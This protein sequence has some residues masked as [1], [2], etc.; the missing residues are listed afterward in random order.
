MDEAGIDTTDFVAS[1]AQHSTV[2]FGGEL[3]QHLLATAP[4][5]DAVF[6]CNDDL[7][8]GVLFACQ[9]LNIRVPADLSIL[10]FN[11]LDFAAS[12][13]PAL[14]SVATPRH[15]M[16]RRAAEIILQIIRAPRQRPAETRVDLGFKI[17]EWEST[18]RRAGVGP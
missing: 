17:S 1:S 4:G 8:L 13:Y 14:T 12:A 11:D 2:K 9:R 6:C 18:R 16:A 5:I 10:G 3:F 7:A 15:E